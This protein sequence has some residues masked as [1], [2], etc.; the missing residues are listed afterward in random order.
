MKLICCGSRLWMLLRA[1][2]CNWSC[3][4]R[5]ASART[6]RKQLNRIPLVHTPNQNY[7]K[8]TRVQML[9]LTPLQENCSPYRLCGPQSEEHV[10]MLLPRT[11][12]TLLAARAAGRGVRRDVFLAGA[13]CGVT[14]NFKMQGWRKALQ[15]LT[16]HLPRHGGPGFLQSVLSCSAWSSER[17]A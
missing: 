6:C 16:P 15:S 5:L 8:K 12:R 4:E 9:T 11:I 13:G 14:Q 10:E 7:S 3:P 1:D 2:A 17:L